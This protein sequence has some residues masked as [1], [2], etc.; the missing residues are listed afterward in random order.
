METGTKLVLPYFLIVPDGGVKV[1]KNE[2]ISHP[3]LKTRVLGF[4]PNDTSIPTWI[5]P[6]T[7]RRS[8]A[9]P[10]IVNGRG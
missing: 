9:M 3:K 4:Q 6:N 1:D 5:K 8:R 10:L 7:D 2:K